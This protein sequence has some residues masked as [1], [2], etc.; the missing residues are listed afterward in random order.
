MSEKYSNITWLKSNN[1][2]ISTNQEL[3]NFINDTMS[4]KE[5]KVIEMVKPLLIAGTP[6]EYVK[7]M[8]KKN[9]KTK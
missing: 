6:F 5:D 4:L 8:I 1:F 3:I 2:S 7:N 9:K